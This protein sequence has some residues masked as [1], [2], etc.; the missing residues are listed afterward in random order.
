MQIAASRYGISS[1]LTGEAGAVGG[2]DRI[3]AELFCRE[4]G[5]PLDRLWPGEQRWDDLDQLE[6]RDGVEEVQ[7]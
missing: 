4:G 2:A 5:D 6:D 7:P 1:A 3:L